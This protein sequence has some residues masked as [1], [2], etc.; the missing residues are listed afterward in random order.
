MEILNNLDGILA[1]IAYV[2]AAL[3]LLTEAL[4]MLA[5]LTATKK[6]DAIF[7]AIH[8]FLK[9]AAGMVDK[10]TPVSRSAPGEDK[11][12]NDQAP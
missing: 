11:P 3:V 9:N 7:G 12:K 2:I 5:K 4:G 8:A 1:T 10:I 6:D